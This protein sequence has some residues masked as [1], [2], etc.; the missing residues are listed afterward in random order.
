MSFVWRW[1]ELLVSSLIGCCIRWTCRNLL[2]NSFAMARSEP[3]PCLDCSRSSRACDRDGGVRARRCVNIRGRGGD[4]ICNYGVGGSAYQC[5]PGSAGGRH[6]LSPH[7]PG[8][9]VRVAPGVLVCHAKWGSRGVGGA[10]ADGL[11]CVA[12]NL[13]SGISST[14]PP[15]VLM[16]RACGSS[17]RNMPGDP[18][19]GIV[20]GVRG[21]VRLLTSP[22]SSIIK[23]GER[24]LVGGPMHTQG[25][26]PAQRQPNL[27]LS[28]LVI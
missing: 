13:S 24:V 11:R 15:P 4:L 28:H 20:R 12:L 22:I 18:G 6:T 3:P 1:C 19:L 9:P 10:G 21:R 26:R 23:N 16:S 25:A 5:V 17:A 8:Y 14:Q 2:A 27:E 7:V